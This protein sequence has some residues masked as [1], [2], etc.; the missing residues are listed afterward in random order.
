MIHP[1]SMLVIDDDPVIGQF[2]CRLG[3]SLDL[4][5]D[6]TTTAERFLELLRPE[7]SLIFLDLVMPGIDGIQLLR[8]LSERKCKTPIIIM[9]G[10][11]RRVLEVAERLAKALELRVVGMLDMK[12]V[13]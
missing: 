6:V 12:F 1:A 11:E 7:T 5:C 4:R 13:V 8:L 3:S 2:L 10:I 9:S